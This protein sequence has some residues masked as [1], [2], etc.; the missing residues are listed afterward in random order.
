VHD[1]ARLNPREFARHSDF[2]SIRLVSALAPLA[3]APFYLAMRGAPHLWESLIFVCAAMPLVS[4]WVLSRTGNFIAAQALSIVGLLAGSVALSFGLGGVTAASLV[5]LVLA[6]VEAFFALSS[7]LVLVTLAGALATLILVAV[8]TSAGY[9]PR[10]GQASLLMHVFF[11]AP[12][13]AHIGAM[14]LGGLR[15]LDIVKKRERLGAARFD[16]LAGAM[17]DQVLR[18]DRTGAV[19]PSGNSS[20]PLFGI[21]TREYLGRGLFER[22]LVQDRP[23]FLKCVSD[24]AT[25]EETVRCELRLRAGEETD[26]SGDFHAPI[27]HWVELRARSFAN[28]ETEGAGVIALLRDLSREKAREAEIDAAREEAVRSNAWKDRFIANMSHELRTP[29]NAIIGFSEML[30][31]DEIAVLGP[32]KR[33]EYAEIVN[34]SGQHL[35][36]VVNSI[37]DISKLE[38]GKFDII[39][40]PFELAPLIDSCCDMISLRAVQAGVAIERDMPEDFGEIVGD[41]RACK[42][43]LINL[44]S[45]ALKFT[46]RGGKI[47]IAARSEASNVA[48]EISDSGVGIDAGELT[49]LGE[50][51]YQA[52]GAYN[53]RFEGTGLGLSIVRGLVGLHGGSMSIESGQGE[54]TTVIVRLPRSGAVVSDVKGAVAAIETIARVGPRRRAI[55]NPEQ[56]RVKKIA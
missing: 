45:N 4:V 37:L 18:L 53:R 24:A 1:K 13:I 2:I 50:V 54:G 17:G 7:R 19:L 49:R 27:F 16:A 35:L 14:T 28:R 10:D 52:G 21:Q 3:L 41:K 56:S 34:S 32:H 23:A 12:A 9:M 55:E 29:L 44:L 11:I 8:C 30:G 43:I 47:E 15:Q 22:V 46:P 33:K 51:F 38:A 25:S 6:P 40:E 36:S 26:V 39:A 5:W 48:I 42:Q 20:A 31:S